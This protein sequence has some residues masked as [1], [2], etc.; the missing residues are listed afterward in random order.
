[1]GFFLDGDILYKKRKYQI[2]LRCV[3]ADEAKKIVYEIHEGACGTHASRHVMTRQIMRAGYYWMTLESDCI[4]YVRKCHKCQIY[5][6]KIHVPPIVLNVMVSPWPFSMWDMVV[7][8]PITP[9]ASNGH[10]FIFVVI[11]YF[12][13]WVKVASYAS[14]TKSVVARF[15]KRE[16]ICQYGLPERI[17]SDNGLNLNNDMVT[18]VCTRFKIKHHN[19]VPYRPKM[20]GAVEAANKNMKKIIA[21]ATET[22]KDW[23]EKLPFTLHAYRIGVQTS[24]EATSYSLVYG[25][26][27]VLP[28]KVE[29]P[30]LRVLKEVELEEVEWIQA[31]HEQLNLIEEK[32][33]KAI[34]HGQLYQKRMM[35]AH[36]KKIRPRQFREGELVLKW[37]S[38]NRQ[39]PRE[40]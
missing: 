14:V 30:S 13:K 35:R 7:I 34:Y 32:R 38:Q 16:I 19:S 33:M 21:K 23:H 20:N 18:K 8:E 39:D 28:I 1:M 37:I 2:L 6:D 12:T 29:I 31:R 40:K 11:D 5:A 10:R 24:T 22:Y 26:E 17:I 9:K 25:M 27:V 4:T 3:D 15:I 36:N